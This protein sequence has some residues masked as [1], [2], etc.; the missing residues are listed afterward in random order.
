MLVGEFQSILDNKHQLNV[1]PP[2][3]NFCPE[4]FASLRV[5]LDASGNRG[6]S[7]RLGGQE[8][9]A[10]PAARHQSPS[11]HDR[12]RSVD[13]QKPKF[14]L[15]RHVTTRHA[16]YLAHAFWHE[17]KSCRAVSCLSCSTA[18]HARH[19][20]RG[21]HDTYD[22]CSGMPPQRGLGWTCPP[23]YFQK[24]FLRP[25]QIRSTKY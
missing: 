16:C 23:H 14:H 18:R 19:D 2:L 9:R 5:P 4:H 7:R 22:R 3:P 20:K 1:V 17:N 21:L 25:M 10:A 8:R 11:E 6:T 24:L 13:V 12:C 15:A